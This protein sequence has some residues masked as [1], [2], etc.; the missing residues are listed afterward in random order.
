MIYLAGSIICT[1]LLFLFFKEFDKRKI[2]ILHAITANYF[3][4]ALL[5][6]S[7][8]EANYPIT[9]LLE[10]SWIAPCLSLGLIFILMFNVMALTTQRLGV[11]IASMSSKM[12]LVIPVIFAVL[13]QGEF[14]STLKII[15][16]IIALASVY[17][18]MKKGEKK[19]GP[20]YLAVLLFIGS[21]T[22]DTVI[23]YVQ[24]NFLSEKSDYDYFTTTIFLTAFLLGSI[25]MLIKVEKPTL[26]SVF[27]GFLLAIPNYFSI[28]FMLLALSTLDDSVAFPILNIGVVSLSAIVAWKFYNEKLTALNWCGVF[29]ACLS[30]IILIFA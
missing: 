28:Y 14:F 4:A 17:L 30:I 1:I 8:G 20:I 6:Y 12:S 19:N 3:F 23:S 10:Q 15:A 9:N 11:T 26:K 24:F 2:K 13:L 21:G 16:I 22:L 18:T 29:L 7:L 27:G 5:S 25:S